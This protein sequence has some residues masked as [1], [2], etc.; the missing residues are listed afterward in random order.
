MQYDSKI[1]EEVDAYELSR[2]NTIE[3]TRTLK[4]SWNK[5]N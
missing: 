2:I 5:L 3:E 4:V 1:S